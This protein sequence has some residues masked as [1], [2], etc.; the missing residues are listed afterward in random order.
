VRTSTSGSLA[1]SRE[2]RG[3]MNCGGEVFSLEPDEL[4][5]VQA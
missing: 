4:I 1:G 2:A 5:E 3:R